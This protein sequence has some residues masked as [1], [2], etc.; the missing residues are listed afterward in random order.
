MNLIFLSKQN[1]KCLTTKFPVINTEHKNLLSDVTALTLGIINLTNHD[2]I[3]TCVAT[4]DQ[5]EKIINNKTPLRLQPLID[6]FKQTIFSGRV[7]KLKDH[8]VD[9]KI[10]PEVR[11]IAQKECKIPFAL[12]NK[13]N[14]EIQKLESEGIVEDVTNEP[15]PWINPLVIVPKSGDEI[16]LCVDMRCANKAI[17]RTRYPTTTIDEILIKTKEAKKFSPN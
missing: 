6:T 15:M 11:P 16:R 9:L 5:T 12:R 2:K 13:V 17:K 1:T 7:G 8:Q 4:G 10:N 3:N 14:R